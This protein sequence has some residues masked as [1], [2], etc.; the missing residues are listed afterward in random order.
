MKKGSL[1]SN[2]GCPS[3]RGGAL[4]PKTQQKATRKSRA[5]ERVDCIIIF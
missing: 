3:S 1:L 5:E 2:L 4:H